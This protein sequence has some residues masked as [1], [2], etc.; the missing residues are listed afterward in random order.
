V[1]FVINREKGNESICG[2]LRH[3]YGKVPVRQLSPHSLSL[4]EFEMD[5]LHTGAAPTNED[6]IKTSS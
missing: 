6:Q 3:H 1:W 5:C 4:L 2:F